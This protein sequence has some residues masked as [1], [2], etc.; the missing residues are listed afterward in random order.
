M[1]DLAKQTKTI[2][3]TTA[4]ATGGAFYP[5]RVPVGFQATQAGT[6]AQT[7][8]TIIEG[9]NEPSNAN[10][11]VTVGTIT[12]SGTTTATDG[13]STSAGFAAFR[14]RCT[15]ITGTSAVLNLTMT[16]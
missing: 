15:A 11:W 12:L 16:F 9:T 7:S 5:F 3:N 4:T 10:S 14:A 6:G 2:L 1:Y 8:T 13:F